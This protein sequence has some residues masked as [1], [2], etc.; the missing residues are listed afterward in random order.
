MS[1]ETRLYNI[2]VVFNLVKQLNSQ[3]IKPEP[4]ALLNRASSVLGITPKTTKEYIEALKT[5]IVING[6]PLKIKFYNGGFQID[7]Q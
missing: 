1:V 7:S 6:K 5:G 2:Q 4:M 3:G